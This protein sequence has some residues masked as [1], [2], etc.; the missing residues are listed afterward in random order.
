[1][2]RLSVLALCIF[3][4]WSTAFAQNPRAVSAIQANGVYRHGD[5]EFRILA[6]G[7]GTLKVQFDGIYVTAARGQNMGYATGEATLEGTV[8][9]FIPPDTQG[10][11]ITLTFSQNTLKVIQD[12]SDA[13]CGFGH[14]VDATGTYRKI[15]G[16]KPKFESRPN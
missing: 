15:R 14:N 13:D 5:N 12:G 3:A 8:A 9:R 1:M 16:G 7:S 11:K 2:P 10:C 4:S 6:L